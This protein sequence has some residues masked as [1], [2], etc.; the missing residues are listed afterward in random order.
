MNIRLVDYIKG[1]GLVRGQ[2]VGLPTSA[3]CMLYFCSEPSQVADI[4]EAVQVRL[5]AYKADKRDLGSV[6]EYGESLWSYLNI[7]LGPRKIEVS[8]DYFGSRI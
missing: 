5:D 6:S 7:Y 1:V 3:C 4:A 8:A 2:L